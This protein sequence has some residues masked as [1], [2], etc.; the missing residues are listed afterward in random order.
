M[1]YLLNVI[2]SLFC[3]LFWWAVGK[4]PQRALWVGRKL[5]LQCLLVDV[6]LEITGVIKCHS[7]GEKWILCRDLTLWSLTF[8][9]LHHHSGL[10][11]CWRWISFERLDKDMN[12]DI[13]KIGITGGPKSSLHFIKQL[14]TKYKGVKLKHFHI[15]VVLMLFFSAE[16]RN[17]VGW[18]HQKAEWIA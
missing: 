8:S 5:L 4:H 3:K 13:D 18:T 15:C 16:A 14:N 2:C 6:C 7:S 17:G 12:V 9:M 11:I 1:L 10:H